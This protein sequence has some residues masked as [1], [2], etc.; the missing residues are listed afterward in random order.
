MTIYFEFK[1]PL[2][3]VQPEIW[4]SFLLRSG[5]TFYEL[6]D[7]IQ[8]ACGWQ[9]YHLFE[10][11]GGNRIAESPYCKGFGDGCPSA[12]DIKINSFFEKAGDKC[13]YEYDFGN[14]WRHI[15]TLKSINKSSGQF[16][17]K[18]TGG[19][20]AFPLEDSGSIPGYKECVD[21]FWQLTPKL[22]TWM[23]M[24]GKNFYQ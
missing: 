15:V 20:R 21:A 19:Q 12:E 14:C 7:T 23:N 1:V 5:S 22:K 18:L 4:R 24:P 2:E 6:H 17:R 10:F 8:K 9:D 11:I 16:R 3:G 13:I